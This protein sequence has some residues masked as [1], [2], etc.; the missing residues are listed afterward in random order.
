MKFCCALLAL[1]LTLGNASAASIYVGVTSPDA[2]GKAL[3]YNLREEIA[4]SSRH[5]LVI[6]E[7][8]AMFRL[9]IVTLDPDKDSLR[10]IYSVVLNLKNYA[11]GQNYDYHVTSWV[12]ICGRAAVSGCARNIASNLDAEIQ[13]IAEAIVKALKNYQGTGQSF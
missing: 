13:P 11:D 10:T 4:A 7:S 5:K 2:V 12:G 8:D 6:D 3:A 1:F 9:S